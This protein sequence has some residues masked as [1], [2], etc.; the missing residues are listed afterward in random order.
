MTRSTMVV[1]V[2]T[3]LAAGAAAVELG[4]PG[5]GFWPHLHQLRI[6]SPAKH[7]GHDRAILYWKDPDGKNDFSS[8]PKKTPDGRDYVPVYEDQEA[9]LTDKKPAEPL[10]MTGKILYY[11]NPMGLPDVSPAP[12][13]TSWGWT[14]SLS[15]RARWKT[16]QP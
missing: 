9:G 16:G 10:R 8:E 11:R 1:V 7:E 12:K 6:W 2:L 14:M 3:T 15:M 5:S 4:G 13:K